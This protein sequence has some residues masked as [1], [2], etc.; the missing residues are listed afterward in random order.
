[1]IVL[2]DILYKVTINA[3]VGDTSIAISA[4]EFN[5]RRV[6]NGGVFVAIKGNV[7]DGHKGIT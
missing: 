4:I 2:K 3:V 6:S 7:V 5:S 1:M